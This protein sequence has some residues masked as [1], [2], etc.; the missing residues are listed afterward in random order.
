VERALSCSCP[1]YNIGFGGHQYLLM[2]MKATSKG[3]RRNG[4]KGVG[5]RARCC[6]KL[7]PVEGGGIIGY[8]TVY[9]FSGPT[10]APDSFPVRFVI[11]NFVV[12]SAF[13]KYSSR[14]IVFLFLVVVV[15][16]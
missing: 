6:L 9:S 13:A 8:G 11:C 5:A 10:C 3:N 4:Q 15:K 2:L 14:C 16:V 12:F 1:P 7:V